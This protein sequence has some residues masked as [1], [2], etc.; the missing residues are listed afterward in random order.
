MN[1][2]LFLFLLVVSAAMMILER[3]GLPT[4]L[5]LPMKGDIKRESRFLAQYGQ[6]ICT[7]IAA[8]LVLQLDRSRD[9]GGP[10]CGEIV[11]VIAGVFIASVLA[12]IVKRLTG[13][14]RPGRPEAGRFLGFSRKHANYRESF[15]S[16]HSA[17]A[18][19]FSVGMAHMYPPAAVTFI[20]LALICAA[21]RYFLDAHWPSDIFAGIALGYGSAIFSWW[22]LVILMNRGTW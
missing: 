21:L 13:R 14:V 12:M 10:H 5:H 9:H 11:P 1:F 19:A 16:S 6:V 2:T 8:I 20:V 3:L 15:P 7:A 22:I 17:S 4:T 18:M